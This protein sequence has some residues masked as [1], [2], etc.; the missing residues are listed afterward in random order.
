MK[1]KRI[2]VAVD[3]QACADALAG[4]LTRHC[5]L[6]DS[7]FLI[8][9]VIET[10]VVLDIEPKYWEHAL[11]KANTEGRALV[12]ELAE[13]VR[14]AQP[15]LLVEEMVLQG[16][17]KDLILD[18]VTDWGADLVVLGSRGRRGF[19]RFLLGSVSQAVASHAPCSVL[20]VRLA[21]VKTDE[22]APAAAVATRL[23][24]PEQTDRVVRAIS[25]VK[26]IRE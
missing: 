18:A 19:T 5:W 24:D 3:S 11:A 15:G 1:L 22:K 10:D 7:S 4:F 16:N 21:P 2:L 26:A 12:N 17:P 14:K 8:L 6:G 13:K 25:R 9:H 23:K 20:V